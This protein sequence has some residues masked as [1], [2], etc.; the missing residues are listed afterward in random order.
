MT[1]MMK[2]RARRSHL[3]RIHQSPAKRKR[4]SLRV[5]SLLL[6]RLGDQVLSSGSKKRKMLKV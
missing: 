4:K 1:K 5:R 3:V 2:K 6:F